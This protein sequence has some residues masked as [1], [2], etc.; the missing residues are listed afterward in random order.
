MQTYKHWLI[1]CSLEDSFESLI[2]WVEI[3]VQ[4][5]EEAQGEM[6]AFRKRKFDG[7][8]PEGG[9]MVFKATEFVAEPLPP[10]QSQ[11]AVL[12]T[13]ASRTTHYGFVK[14]LR[15]YLLRKDRS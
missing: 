10:N 11:E 9:K 4:I 8:L 7:P 14:P 5:M 15:S 13:C 1:Y 2:E 12:L 6:S 3:W